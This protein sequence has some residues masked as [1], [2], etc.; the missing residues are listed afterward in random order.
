MAVAA[1]FIAHSNFYLAHRPNALQ[2]TAHFREGVDLFFAISGMLITTLLITEYEHH[3]RVNFRSF[4]IRRAF[5]ILPPIL[6]YLAVLA[7]LAMTRL[8]HASRWEFPSSL[9]FYR[10][11]VEYRSDGGLLTGHF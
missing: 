7:L 10:N 11:Y 3:G 6:L 5:R 4:Y 1:V 9:L 8:V 2:I